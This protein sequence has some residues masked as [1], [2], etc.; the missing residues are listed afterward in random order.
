VAPCRHGQIRVFYDGNCPFCV[1]S[2]GLLR[3]LDWFGRLCCLD[4]RREGVIPPNLPAERLLEEMHV[5]APS[6]RRVY[7]GFGALRYLAWR[8]PLLWIIAPFLYI[9][10]VAVIGQRIYLLIA[11]NRFQLVPC[12]AGVCAALSKTHEPTT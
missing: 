3:R 10:G 7:H 9:P 5:L 1:R 12:H 4:A 6:V 2:V 8:L 11:R